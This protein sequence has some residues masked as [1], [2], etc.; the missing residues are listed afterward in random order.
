M[1]RLRYMFFL[2][3]AAV[4]LSQSLMGLDEP[5]VKRGEPQREGRAWVE[6]AECGAAV[7]NGARMLLRADFGSITV[8]TGQSNRV[9]CRIRLQVYKASE[10]EAKRFFRSVELTAHALEGGGLSFNENNPPEHDR[11]GWS[12]ADFDFTVPRRFNLDMETKGGNVTVGNL[13]GELRAATA[14][15]N[16]QT[17]DISGPVRVE[18]AGG[19]INVG[20][21]GQRLMAKTA[22]GSIRANDIKGDATLETSG[23]EITAGFI[24]GAVHAQTSGG[25]IGLRGAT[26]P[27]SAQ[28][29]GGQIQIGQCGA[30]IHAETA[31]GSIHLQGAKGGVVVQTAGGSI[32]LYRMQSAVRA[33]TAAGR[34]LAEI[35]ANRETFAPSHLETSM[36]DIQ[37]FLPPHLALNIDALIKESMGNRIVSDFPLHLTREEDAFHH[38][39]KRGEGS[40]NGG[41]KVLRIR[42]VMGNIEI[43]KLDPTIIE[44]FKRRQ[45][46][47]WNQWE[48]RQK[49]LRIKCCTNP[50]EE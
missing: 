32:D 43:H 13:D 24:E 33:A 8:H 37:V 5:N 30:S 34:I 7:R 39:P 23:G 28:T 12:A 48:E 22:G 35:N 45:Q 41:G 50:K 6:H 29:A 47:Y 46:N 14:G 17:G 21:I 9:E 10:D 19:D 49:A 40:L 2:G 20:N 42:T 38:G 3:L 18:T 27:V 4:F 15:G 26:G 1:V 25:D 16:I 31:G 44:Q 36:G 11:S